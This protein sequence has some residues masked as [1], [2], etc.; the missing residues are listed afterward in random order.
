MSFLSVPVQVFK[1]M[2]GRR[3]HSSVPGADVDNYHVVVEYVSDTSVRY[4][5]G[6][7]ISKVLIYGVGKA[8]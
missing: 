2:V 1:Q 3:I 4:R 7:L 6:N 8:S 5:C